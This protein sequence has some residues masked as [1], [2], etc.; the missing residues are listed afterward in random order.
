MTRTR[1]DALAPLGRQME[2][3]RRELGLTLKQAAAAC[4]LTVETLRAVRYGENVPQGL[5]R[6]AI[7]KGLR[8]EQGSVGRFL[9]DG[10]QP[11][12]LPVAPPGEPDK[13]QAAAVVFPGDPVAQ[14]I[15]T[16]TLKDPDVIRREL[17]EWLASQDRAAR[18]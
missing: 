7:E 6:A 16:Q 8:W 11:G 9:E 18:A 14:A 17:A 10:T 1:D 15:V 12:K 3:R 4:G 5:T 2:E 13:A